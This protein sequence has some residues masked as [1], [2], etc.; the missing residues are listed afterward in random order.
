MQPFDFAVICFL[1]IT[2]IFALI[3]LQCHYFFFAFSVSEGELSFFFSLPLKR[4]QVFMVKFWQIFWQSSWMIFL[5]VLTFLSALQTYFIFRHH[6]TS[7]YPGRDKLRLNP[8]GL[9][10]LSPCF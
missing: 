9:G 6:C 3:G 5:G 1:F 2:G 7:G 8:V 10:V 4:T